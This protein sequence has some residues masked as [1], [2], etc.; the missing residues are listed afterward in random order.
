MNP[1]RNK[2]KNLKILKKTKKKHLISSPRLPYFHRILHLCVTSGYVY[3]SV[4]TMYILCTYR[5]CGLYMS[6]C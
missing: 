6:R 3:S 5:Y 4:N 1:T 2:R